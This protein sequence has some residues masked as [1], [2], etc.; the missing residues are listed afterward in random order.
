MAGYSLAHSAADLAANECVLAAALTGGR[1]HLGAIDD[2]VR[3][4]LYTGLLR[5]VGSGTNLGWSVAK[6][7]TER[8]VRVPA[9]DCVLSRPL[10]R[11]LSGDPVCVDGAGRKEGHVAGAAAPRTTRH[12]TPR[13]GRVSR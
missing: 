6:V 1:P 10:G 8:G 3:R 5:A 7:T 11:R 2:G 12:V 9:H 4:G 13:G